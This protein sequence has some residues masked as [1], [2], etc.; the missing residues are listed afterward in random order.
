MVVTGLMGSGGVVE[1]GGA[2]GAPSVRVVAPSAPGGELERDD[3]PPPQL[4]VVKHPVEIDAPA[5]P[6]FDL[7]ATAP[8]V[9]SPRELRVRGHRTLGSEIKVAGY[10]TW[11]YDCRQELATAN[12]EA[13]PDQITRAI[14]DDATLCQRP[15][16]L[17]GDARNTPRDRSVLVVEAAAMPRLAVGDPAIV[18][19]TWS[20]QPPHAE[21]SDGALIYKALE[22]A[23]AAGTAHDALPAPREIAIELDGAASPPLRRIVDETTINSSIAHLNACN[24]AN[25]AKHFDAA[26]AECHSATAIWHDNHLAWYATASAHLAKRQWPEARAAIDNAV[27]LRPD[28]AMY[29]LYL[30]IALYESERQRVRDVQARRE[31]K[32]PDEVELDPTL[33]RLDAARDALARAVKLVPELWRAHYYLG[34]IYR[35]LD[36]A[37]RAAA[38]FTQTIKSHPGYRFA[39]IALSELYRRWDYLDQALAVAVLGAGRVAAPDSAE[40]WF[41]AGMAHQARHADDR[42]I[43]A[44]SRAIAAGDL[45]SKLQRGQVYL[46]KRDLAAARRDLE[47]VVRAPDADAA[48][49][50]QLAG[51]L[52]QEIASTRNAAA[53]RDTRWDCRRTRELLVCHPRALPSGARD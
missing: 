40:L 28:L 52:L 48:A 17:L 36:D 46:H 51:Q 45:P 26:I 4:E 42:A 10:V 24:K 13:T 32:R 37:Q 8:G 39:Y 21:F 12:P 31:H 3:L 27:V 34:R 18:V 16:F 47:D 11:I 22:P 30:G 23:A 14:R 20:R 6:A 1:A 25:A 29:Q 5:I 15:M 9:R 35:D 49:A 7:P 53:A 38:E 41:E 50:R 43:D 44:F 33:L 19:G 2:H